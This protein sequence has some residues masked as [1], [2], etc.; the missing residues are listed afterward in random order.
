MERRQCE[1]TVEGSRSQQ[2]ALTSTRALKNFTIPRKKRTSAE[3]L[4]EHCS[5]ESR[6]YSLIQTKLRDSNLDTRKDRANAWIWRDICLVHNEEL[7]KKFSEK[8]AEMRA[9]GRHGREMEESFCFLSASDQMAAEIYQHGLRVGN[10]AQHALGKPSHGVYLFKH[11]DVALKST[12]STLSAKKIVIFKVLYGKVKK[13]VPSLDCNKTQDP[14]VSFDCHMCKD[15]VS[16]RD[17]LHQQV[18][19]STVFL[20]DYNEKQELSERPRQCLPY[21]VVSFIP[22]S[23]AILTVPANPPLSPSAQPIGH[24]HDRFKACTVAER[25]RKGKTATVTF[26]HFGMPGCFKTDYTPQNPAPF[27]K[28]DLQNTQSHKPKQPQTLANEDSDSSSSSVPVMDH[29]AHSQSLLGKKAFTLGRNYSKW[30]TK[31]Q[32]PLDKISTIVYSSRLVRDPRLSRQEANQQTN[33]LEAEEENTGPECDNKSSQLA[34]QNQKDN[35]GNKSDS[36][37]PSNMDQ[38]EAQKHNDC[39]LKSSMIDQCVPIPALPSMK[40]FKMKFQKYAAYFRMNEEER[41]RSIWLQENMSSE[42]KQEL[43]DRIHFYEDYYEKYKNGLLFQKISDTKETSSRSQRVPKENTVLQTKDTYEQN[44]SELCQAQQHDAARFSDD[45]DFVNRDRPKWSTTHIHETK[46]LDHPEPSAVMLTEKGQDYLLPETHQEDVDHPNGCLI[47]S[48]DQLLEQSLVLGSP[49]LNLKDKKADTQSIQF[50]LKHPL[51]SASNETTL[52]YSIECERELSRSAGEDVQK[53]ES[54]PGVNLDERPSTESSIVYANNTIVMDIASCVEVSISGTSDN[55]NLSAAMT[56][57]QK[58]NGKSCSVQEMDSFRQVKCIKHSEISP[59]LDIETVQLDYSA[60]RELYKRLQLDQLLPSKNQ[61]HVFSSRAYLTPRDMGRPTDTISKPK[62][63][64]KYHSKAETCS[65]DLHLIVTLKANKMP[66]YEREMLSLTE[67]FSKIKAF[68]K[69]LSGR[70]NKVVQT[71]GTQ[72]CSNEGH[73]RTAT[74]NAE[75]IQL[76]AQRFSKSKISKSLSRPGS[77]KTQHTGHYSRKRSKYVRKTHFCKAKKNLSRRTVSAKTV[78]E[79]VHIKATPDSSNGLLHLSEKDQDPDCNLCVISNISDTGD[80]R[81]WLHIQSCQKANAF[82]SIVQD[83]C[84]PT[85]SV[86]RKH[87]T[88]PIGFNT[89]P[90]AKEETINPTEPCSEDLCQSNSVYS[91]KASKDLNSHLISVMVDGGEQVR[92]TKNTAKQ[93]KTPLITSTNKDYGSITERKEETSLNPLSKE[94][95]TMKISVD[96]NVDA[97]ESLSIH[98]YETSETNS[99]MTASNTSSSHTTEHTNM[100]PEAKVINTIN[101]AS[102]TETIKFKQNTSSPDV[103]QM[104]VN[105]SNINQS[106]LRISTTSNGSSVWS[107]DTEVLEDATLD[108]KQCGLQALDC[109]S[110][111]VVDLTVDDPALIGQR[112]IPSEH[113]KSNNP[114]L[115]CSNNS[116][117]THIVKDKCDLSRLEQNKKDD[118]NSPE[119]QLISKLRDY[120]TKFEST[121]KKQEAVNEDLKERPVMWITLDSTAHKQQLFEKGQYCM[122][123]LPCLMPSE[124]DTATKDNSS[125]CT[126]PPVQTQKVPQGEQAQTVADVCLLVPVESKRGRRSSH[127]KRTKRSRRSSVTSVSPDSTSVLDTVKDNKSPHP[128][129]QVNDPKAGSPEISINNTYNAQFQMQRKITTVQQNP[130][131]NVDTLCERNSLGNQSLTTIEIIDDGNVSSTFADT[132]YSI[133]DISNTLRLAD[134]TNLLTELESLQSK[135]KNMLQ[136]FISCFERDQKVPFNQSFVSRC[137]VLEQYLDHPPAEV[138]LKYEAVNSYLELQMMMEAWQFV[139]NKINFMQGKPTFRSLLWYDPSLYGELYKGEVGFQQQSSLFASFQKILAQEGY[140]KLQEYY[141][142]VSSLHRQLHVAPDASYYM[143]LKSKRELLEAEAALRNPHDIKSFFLSVP[144]AAMINFGDNLERLEKV[145]KVIMTFVETPSDQLPGTFDVG[146]AEHLSIACRYLQE[147]ALFLKSCKEVISKISWFGIEHLLYD[148]SKVL[149]WQDMVHGAPSEAL[150]TYKNSNP[151]IIFGV[152]E[153]GVALVNK[154]KQPSTSVDGAETKQKSD[155]PRK[156]K[157]LQLRMPTQ[158]SVAQSIKVDNEVAYN[159]A[160]RRASHPPVTQC[161]I[162][163][164]VNPLFQTTPATHVEIPR[165]YYLPHRVDPGHWRKVGSTAA[166]W[167]ASLPSTSHAHTE[168][169]PHF[170]SKRQVTLSHSDERRSLADVQK[171]KWPSVSVPQATL[172]RDCGVT[173][174][175]FDSIKYR[176]NNTAAYLPSLSQ[177]Q[178]NQFS[179]AMTRPYNLPNFPLNANVVPP[180]LSVQAMTHAPMPSPITAIHYPYFLLNGQTYTTGS[181][182]AIHPETRYYPNTMG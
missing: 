178:V 102:E 33:C 148:A 55:C 13:I 158:P 25:R 118:A 122:V 75:L 34:C 160:K 35:Y 27:Q 18:L 50:N 65:E 46:H 162:S 30:D 156:R 107:T 68:Q 32:S 52:N 154:V 90:E 76:L 95:F 10:T 131:E 60:H 80:D 79:M 108:S 112:E 38:K 159:M 147:K 150:K 64:S 43:T 42:Q 123:N 6:D 53:N 140:C 1:E 180:A 151:Q 73:K 12:T 149:V 2:A 59:E 7:L 133:S 16:R 161:N 5:E 172:R 115:L 4:L 37:E 121:V 41:H 134:E 174:S 40:L 85:V 99:D 47:Q 83:Q 26:K 45:Y 143:Y 29:T 23:S 171:A 62:N 163:N 114:N 11:V 51:T 130:S 96:D 105:I 136:H 127:T 19:G 126:N 146:K 78:N 124:R 22:A 91:E 182:A 44:P 97:S 69:K 137:L 93:D 101:N 103:Q 28:T 21:A 61:K 104:P 116:P 138:D 152:T 71:P 58:Q 106:C 82:R 70:N 113:I 86:I 66:A 24:S 88:Q 173:H 129:A 48:S 181:N 31:Y 81:Q 168:V 120:L 141:S 17:T 128:L 57:K 100:T 117:S 144:I 142:A 54:S 177:E 72:M 176:Q 15:A 36:K 145:Y 14:T 89:I 179:L 9:K 119:T 98:D 67:R 167:N 166:D 74:C 20:F 87:L 111:N 125:E 164:G 8:R 56:V 139:E 63:Q 49:N 92:T 155:A 157:S 153:S 84:C 110:N 39:S 3:V 165:P 109:A 132:E 77:L 135:C 170:I 169:N 175:A 94:H